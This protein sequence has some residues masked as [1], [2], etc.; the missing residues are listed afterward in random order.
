MKNKIKEL[1][2][3]KG[4]SQSDLAKQL[5][6]SRQGISLYEQ[7]KREPKLSTWEQLAN[8]FQVSVPYIQGLGLQDQDKKHIIMTVAFK[9]FWTQEIISLQVSNEE[10]DFYRACEFFFN[11]TKINWTSLYDELTADNGNKDK[12]FSEFKKILLPYIGNIFSEVVSLSYR[13]HEP[14]FYDNYE[15]DKTTEAIIIKGA[16]D[17]FDDLYNEQVLKP[18]YAK[19]SDIALD[20]ENQIGKLNLNNI[21]PESDV[22]KESIIFKVKEDI[23]RA[24]G[25][26]HSIENTLK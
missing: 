21:N 13:I 17:T 18:N 24:Y 6:I 8:F 3:Q 10:I 15:T 16:I 2:E 7:S 1:R 11:Q 19:L 20:I 9:Y 22:N 4:V 25:L 23:K 26:L 5:N 12:A 14:A